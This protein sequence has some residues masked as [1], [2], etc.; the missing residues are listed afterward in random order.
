MKKI[1]V[2]LTFFA[3]VPLSL[4]EELAEDGLDYGDYTSVTLQVK[5]WDALG[6][7]KYEDAV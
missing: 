5:S 2:I 4:A 6:E 1:V 7:G 3:F